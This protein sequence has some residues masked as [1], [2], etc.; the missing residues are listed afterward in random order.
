[1]RCF[2]KIIVMLIANRIIQISEDV[3]PAILEVIDINKAGKCD[4]GGLSGTEK[5][6]A[7]MCF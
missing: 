6:F 2:Y 3:N 7:E 1:M 5:I 4:E